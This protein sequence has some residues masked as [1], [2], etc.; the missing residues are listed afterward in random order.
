MF[1]DLLQV[2][3]FFRSKNAR[4]IDVSCL[5]LVHFVGI[6]AYHSQQGSLVQINVLI[7]ML[8]MFFQKGSMPVTVPVA[9]PRWLP[10]DRFCTQGKDRG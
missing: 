1:F 5:I 10:S 9:V 8:S 2:F 3:V 7:M 6:G 4:E